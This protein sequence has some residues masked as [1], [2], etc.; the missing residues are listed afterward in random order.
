MSKAIIKQ[1]TVGPMMNFAYLIGDGSTRTC[2][3]V[4]PGWEADKI[5]KEAKD[6]GWEIKM[7][8]LTHAHFD[9]ANA[10]KDL[11]ELTQAPIYV[12]KNEASE[13]TASLV[14]H[15]TDEGTRLLLGD[16]EIKCLHT[17]GHTP[18]SQCFVVDGN[19]FTGDTLFVEGCGRVDLPGSDPKKMMF[20]LKRLASL[21]PKLIVYPGH[22]YGPTPTSTIGSEIKGNPF[23]G[24]VG[25]A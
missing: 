2:A 22:D 16:L 7:I 24:E 11:V 6:L 5:V 19:I 14:M 20:S 1:L 3:V 13:L 12:H 10:V 17:P 8:L 9:H 18:G 23:L 21:D 4:D 25:I 15:P